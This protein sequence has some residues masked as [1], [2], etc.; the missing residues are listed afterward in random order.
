MEQLTGMLAV[1]A[2]D[3][4][5][6]YLALAR[7][8]HARG[9][10]AAAHATLARF[11]DLARRRDFVAHL[12]ARGAAVHAQ[13]ALAEGNLAAAVAWADTS[14]LSAADDLSFPREAEYLILAR[15]WITQTASGAAGSV[16]SQAL[17]L[18]DR[19]LAD[20]QA[21][22]RMD[23][24]VEILIVRALALWVQG[25]R[26]DALATIERA[27]VL[28]EP[29]GYIRRFVDD[30][31]PMAE[32]LQAAAARGIAP[33]YVPRLLAAGDVW[34][35]TGDVGR[36]TAMLAAGRRTSLA[37]NLTESLSDRELD[38]LQLIAAGRSNQ[39]I[40]ETLVIAVS[41]VKKHINNLFGKLAVQ[42]RTQA[43]VRARA[44]NLL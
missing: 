9:D 4:T 23:S 1:D 17:H 32:V 41:T 2:E 8:Q 18:L 37:P 20:A 16:L 28:A 14:G 12:V 27:L 44:L 34:L 33:D 40:A 7:L 30:G 6:G 43:L 5:L 3:V 26:R 11:T 38:V 35:Q 10:A 39:E 29:E 15:V 42:S 25:T 21:K 31:L 13:L 19:L 24:V 36:G 22:A